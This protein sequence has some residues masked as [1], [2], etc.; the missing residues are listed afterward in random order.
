MVLR[1]PERRKYGRK[2][3]M[4]IKYQNLHYFNEGLILFCQSILEIRRTHLHGSA[5]F[6]VP[7]MII[8]G[9]H[10]AAILFAKILIWAPVSQS[11]CAFS[12][13]IIT[14]DSFDKYSLKLIHS[15]LPNR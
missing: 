10:F 4:S 11:M 12:F 9:H 1:K 15:Y 13:C 7:L 3:P 5:H 6:T 8:L 2:S 14:P